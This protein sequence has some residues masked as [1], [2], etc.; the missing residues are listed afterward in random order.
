MQELSI[1]PD[2][3]HTTELGAE[4]IKRNLNLQIDD[5][6]LWC[7][8]S[9]K[10]ADNII[11]WGKN[12]YVYR[13]G[14]AITI[15]AKSNTIITAHP[16][17]SNVRSM[18]TSDYICLKEFLYQTIFK[19]EGVELPPRSI[20]NDPQLIAYIKDFGT[21]SGDLGVV[22]EQNGQV[23]GAA[24]VRK[25]PGNGHI[26]D[27]TPKLAISILPE[28]RGYGIGTKLMKKLFVELRTKGY[29]RTSLSVQ[30]ENPALR[31]FKRLGYR[32]T[33]EGL[34]YVGNEAFIMIKDLL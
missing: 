33:E 5:I 21:H 4:R 19:P 8:E 2:K 11:R 26:N 28:F 13:S 25:M 30:K 14:V 12:F 3:L 9:V 23:V 29:S 15:N 34:D 24:W 10:Q 7:K 27:E 18:L 22:A 20:I 1:N 16:I 31:L 32:I 17:N 6:V